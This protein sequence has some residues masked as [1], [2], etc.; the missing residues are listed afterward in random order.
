MTTSRLLCPGLGQAG[1][2][3]TSNC[4]R[5]LRLR[6]HG[7]DERG[8]RVETVEASMYQKLELGLFSTV[9]Y[10]NTSQRTYVSPK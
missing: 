6:E 5:C 4:L 8:R 7:C 10:S 3:R 2:V 1:W 9:A